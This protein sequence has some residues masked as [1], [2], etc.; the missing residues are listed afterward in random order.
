M[1]CRITVAVRKESDRCMLAAL[2]FDGILISAIP[3][4]LPQQ[5][6]IFN[7]VP[8]LVL[9]E[10]QLRRCRPD[11]ILIELASQPGI[12]GGNVISALG[13]PGRF[14][15]EASGTLI[16]RTILRYL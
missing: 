13:L 5:R 15:P 4:Y 8:A 3:E 6:L 11:R 16:A 1:G 12:I 2:G 14:A 10:S 9:E 7:T